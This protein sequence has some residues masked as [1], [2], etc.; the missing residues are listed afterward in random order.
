MVEFRWF[1]NTKI[2]HQKHS[3]FQ[4]QCQIT[5]HTQTKHKKRA[6]SP[7]SADESIQLGVKEQHNHKEIHFIILIVNL[8]ELCNLI[9]R[10]ILIFYFVWSGF[11]NVKNCLRFFVFVLPGLGSR[12]MKGLLDGDWRNLQPCSLFLQLDLLHHTAPTTHFNWSPVPDRQLPNPVVLV[13]PPHSQPRRALRTGWTRSSR[14]RM[15]WISR[16]ENII[17]RGRWCTAAIRRRKKRSGARSFFCRDL[18]QSADK[19]GWLPRENQRE[20]KKQWERI[21]GRWKGRKFQKYIR[22]TWVVS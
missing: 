14:P 1:S 20:R 22:I 13:G 3:Y 8:V 16:R 11:E 21:L 6:R 18:C 2:H 4:M 7:P 12:N 5:I 9:I 19:R 10:R 15:R 17:R